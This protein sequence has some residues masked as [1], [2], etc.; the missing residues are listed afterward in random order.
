VNDDCKT[1]RED[2][3]LLQNK[4][5]TELADGN[6]KMKENFMIN[7]L[8]GYIRQNDVHYDSKKTIALDINIKNYI[9]IIPRMTIKVNLY[10]RD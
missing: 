10:Q 4:Y 9:D 8:E 3:N 6:D 1:Y 5:D 2:S 7:I